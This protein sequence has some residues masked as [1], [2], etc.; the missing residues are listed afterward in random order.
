MPL[1]GD[2][3]GLGWPVHLVRGQSA[4]GLEE[5]TNYC[6]WWREGDRADANLAAE[7]LR[8]SSPG[9]DVGTVAV[10]RRRGA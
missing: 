2:G 3:S 10:H 5:E 8:G 6:E 9:R 4:D 1:F 7:S